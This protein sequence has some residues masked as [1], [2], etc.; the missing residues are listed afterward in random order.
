MG[1]RHTEDIPRIVGCTI[2][3]NGEKEIKISRVRQHIYGIRG[4]AWCVS[5]HEQNMKKESLTRETNETVIVSAV[6]KE[7]DFVVFCAIEKV[8][9]PS[10]GTE[11]WIGIT[12]CLTRNVCRKSLLD[13]LNL[14]PIIRMERKIWNR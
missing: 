13:H 14:R 9:C 7:R 5:Q 1:G 3:T 6:T 4:A 2:R 8:A 12:H 10:N 11:S